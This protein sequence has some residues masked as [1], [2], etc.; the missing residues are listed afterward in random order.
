MKSGESSNLRRDTHST[1]L[2][3][4]FFGNLPGGQPRPETAFDD[5][6]DQVVLVLEVPVNGTGRQPALGADQ[7][8]A[9]ALVAALGADLGGG[10]EDA[11]TR[12]LT[13]GTFAALRLLLLRH[14]RSSCWTLTP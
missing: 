9:G 10:I 14:L 8:D 1:A 3:R 12:Q 4:P 7:G 5:C 6:R 2:R 11:F 13:V